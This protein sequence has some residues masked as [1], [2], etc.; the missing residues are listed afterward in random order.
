[1]PAALVLAVAGPLLLP[2]AVLA[3]ARTGSG[4]HRITRETRRW[5]RAHAPRQHRHSVEETDPHLRTVLR[6]AP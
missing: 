6:P 4:R 5:A 1:M 2:M 3:A